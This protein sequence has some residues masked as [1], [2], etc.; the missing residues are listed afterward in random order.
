MTKFNTD[1]SENDAP[2]TQEEILS[3]LFAHMV[4]QQ[5]N[6]SMMLLGKVA[7]PQTGKYVQD[8][9]SAKLLID[10]L[11]MLE[12]KTKGNLS[13]EE[14]DLLKQ[15]LAALRMAFVDV[16]DK[17]GIGEDGNPEVTQGS[18]QTE[19]KEQ[20]AARVPAQDAP[21]PA[22]AAESKD[23]PDDSRKRFSKKY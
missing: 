12:V 16:V 14:G 4:I 13:K 8:L 1:P 18:A 5:T 3:A 22:A 10:Q 7:H 19:D 20:P 23:T 11:E 6:M 21:A 15:A 9:E 2:A 17:P